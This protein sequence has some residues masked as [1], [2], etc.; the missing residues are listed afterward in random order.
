VLN[1]VRETRGGQLY[2]SK[3]GTRMSG[4]GPYAALLE[5]RF[6]LALRRLG[7]DRRRPEF[8]LTLFRPPGGA[9]EN[10]PRVH[11]QLSLW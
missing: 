4:T 8:D 9:R 2:Q 11:D 7:L 6:K 1:L 3:W 10:K 5:N